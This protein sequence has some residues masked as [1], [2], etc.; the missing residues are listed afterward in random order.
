MAFT[1]F[2]KLSAQAFNTANNTWGAG[3]TTGV[4][5]NTGL[6]SL[7]D[8]ALGGISTFTNPSGA[9]SLSFTAGGGGDV[10]N[11]L[12]RWTGTISADTTI[13]TAAGDATTYLNGFYGW[14]NTTSGSFTLTLTT[15]NG[16]VVLP[17]GRRGV[18][19]VNNVNSIAPFIVSLVGSSTAETI[20]A[21]T[22][23]PFY[24]AAAPAGWTQVMS[25][26]DKALRVVSGTGGVAGGTNAF[27][28]VFAQ[29]A[30]GGYTLALAD[31]P[32]H[33]HT[34]RLVGGGQATSTATGGIMV[35]SGNGSSIVSTNYSAYTGTP[36]DTAGQQIGG[37]GGG[38][39]HS[40]SLT[41]AIQYVDLIL[42]SRN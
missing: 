9:T 7:V 41:M 38:G 19:Y 31:I 10:Q 22:V 6:I 34:F 40:H 11:A 39:S 5:L 42:A 20:P 14:S 29:T 8:Y 33:G 26:N 24:Q 23:M 32:L 18:L 21:G 36:S 13:T 27:S 2:R 12:W 17:Q 15:A 3:G 30:T 37:S 25:Q 28:T 1:Q 35:G 16:S 4:D